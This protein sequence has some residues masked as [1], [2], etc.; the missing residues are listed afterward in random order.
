[1]F[2]GRRGVDLRGGELITL[3]ASA[4]RTVGANGDWVYVGGERHRLIV[5][6][7]T[8]A[9]ATDAGDTLDVFVDTSLDGTNSIGNCV[10]FAQQAGN[11]AAKTEIAVLDAVTP[12]TT[13]IAITS[14]AA[15]GVVRPAL[16][17]AYYRARWAIVDSGNGNSSHTFSVQCYAI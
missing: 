3:A 6:L 9:S 15:A 7:K 2:R 1:M 8:T 11:G 10:H 14:D 13:T 5:V 4:A 12:G 16:F 17:G